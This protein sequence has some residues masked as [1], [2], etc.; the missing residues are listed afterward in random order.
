MTFAT[1]QRL[2]LGLAVLMMLAPTFLFASGKLG[3][4]P[5]FE[6]DSRKELTCLVC[7]GLGKVKDREKKDDKCPT[8][9]GLGV[10]D[11]IIPGPNRPQ[12]LVGTL[13]DS[14][15]RPLTGAEIAIT[16]VGQPADPIVMKTNDD[17]QFGFKFPPGNFH[18]KLTHGALA[19]EQDLKVEPN[20]QPIASTDSETL[21]KFEKTFVLQ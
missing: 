3:Q 16:E 7:D 19:A 9:R 18:L 15:G 11:Y 5:L 20:S 4:S 13:H 21:H 2:L 8:C 12:Q 1:R 14:K 6:G 10:V 17:G